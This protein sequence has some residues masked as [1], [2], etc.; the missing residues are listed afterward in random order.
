MF[1]ASWSG[2]A[3]QR[4]APGLPD[5]NRCSRVAMPGAA[6]RVS[7]A[8]RWRVRLVTRSA[9]PA[10]KVGPDLTKSGAIRSVRDLLESIVLPSASFAQGYESYRVTLADGEEITGI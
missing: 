10:G 2:V 8:T 1:C 9:A 7:S 3:M 6:G 4:R 5:S